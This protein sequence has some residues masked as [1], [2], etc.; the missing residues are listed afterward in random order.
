M[1]KLLRKLVI[2]YLLLSYPVLQKR[3][4]GWQYCENV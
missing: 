4:N 1:R 2:Q 3:G